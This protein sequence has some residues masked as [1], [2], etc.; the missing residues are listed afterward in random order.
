ML[1]VPN[2]RPPHRGAPAIAAERRLAWLRLA[3]QDEPGLVADDRE[4]RRAAQGEAPSYTVDTLAGLRAEHP[5][6]TLVLLVGDDAAAK[7]HTWHRW[8]ALFELAHIAVVE[9]PGEPAEFDPELTAFLRGRKASSPA[10]LRERRSGLWLPVAIP[11]LAISST[12]IRQ[13]L[14]A[15]RSIRGLVPEAVVRSLSTEDVEALTMNEDPAHD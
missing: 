11:P 3:V 13:L 9:R 4:L 8:Q 14:A 1:L 2:A 12:R 15:R 5:D 6:A 10:A 7:L